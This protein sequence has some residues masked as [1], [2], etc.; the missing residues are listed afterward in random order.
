[1]SQIIPYDDHITAQGQEG[2]QAS[3][4]DFG[5]STGAALMGVG[6]GIE[7][8]GDQVRQV[9]SDEARIWAYNQS[10]TAY[11]D[12][13]EGFRQQVDGLDPT[14]PDYQEKIN[15][16]TDQFDKQIQDKTATLMQSAP[17]RIAQKVLAAHMATNHRAL[18]NGSIA[19]QA[20]LNGAHT[21]AQVEQGLKADQDAIAADPS[22]ENYTRVIENRKSLIGGLTTIDPAIKE[23][24]ISSVEHDAAVTQVSV[25]RSAAPASFLKAVNVQGG[26]TTPGGRTKGAVPG[27]TPNPDAPQTSP[28]APG[29]IEQRQLPDNSDIFKAIISQESGGKQFGADGKPLTNSA[30]AIGIAQVMPGTAPEAAKLAG[31]PFDDTKYRNDPE[32]NKALGQAYFNKQLQ[33]FG[34]VEKAAAAYN[35]GPGAVQ[36][37]LDKSAKTGADW[38][39]LLP[40]ET[41]GYVKSI[42][43][44][45]KGAGVQVASNDPSA[46][47][48]QVA[49]LT[50]EDIAAAK[51]SIAG[52][53]KLTWSEKVNQ[54]RQAEAA[55]GGALADE[56]GAMERDLKDVSASLLS[57]KGY[58]GLD[59]SRFSQGN[60]VRLYGPDE[61]KRKF[62]Q[63]QYVKGVGGFMGQMSSMP[64]AQA[65]NLL[66]SLEPQ[67]GPEYAAKAPIYGMASTA[68][69]QRQK[70]MNDDFVSYAQQAGLPGFKPID[71]SSAGNFQLSLHN[72]VALANS[73]RTDYQADAH[74]LSK[75]ETEQLGDLLSRMN[76]K[77]QMEYLKSVKGATNES[78][79][80]FRDTMAAIAPKNTSLA[81]AATVASRD[82][83]V[84]TAAGPQTGN[85][86]GQYILEGAHILQG[87]DIDDPQHTGRPLAIDD[88][89]FRT[90]F[91]NAVGVNAFASPDAQRSNQVAADTM[92]AVKNYLAADVYHR[93]LDPKNVSDD[94]VKN[95]VTAVTGGVYTNNKGDN[96][97]VPWGM[98]KEQFQAELPQRAQ[99]AITQAGLGGTSLDLLD[100]YHYVNVGDGQ[101]GLSNGN[102]MLVGKDGRT[103]I[104]DF[105]KVLPPGAA[106]VGLGTRR[107]S[108]RVID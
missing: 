108:G 21:A 37:A 94:L 70:V 51:P 83:N 64:T 65:V 22:N 14:A 36:R 76:P 93:G 92:Q 17:N 10:S 59:D 26:Y 68:L 58:P 55:L 54:V 89:R 99:A 90:Q 62:D 87:K 6:R 50:D 105:R 31:L 79:D 27:G 81:Q 52:W 15:G 84:V 106:Q 104:V 44:K 91:W 32:Y 85:L 77:D 18:L 97:F 75:P 60:M 88:S 43:A 24:W 34:S 13:K 41:Q 48:P 66:K 28:I 2:G 95:A 4:N 61:G 9:Q 3:P 71:F 35:A 67:A 82:G 33:T 7:N 8:V 30:G 53:D 49:A 80:W 107:V 56:R 5:A 63:L 1:M 73:G 42:N 40:A 69:A 98:P 45:L 39:S 96:V 100:A 16:L 102:R 78:P 46:G 86:V 57:G 20:R 11:S 74:L 47:L 72:R 38:L 23:K 101:Y 12:L 25:M 103:V 29:S 19:E